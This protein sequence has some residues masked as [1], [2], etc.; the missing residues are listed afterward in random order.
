M[1][2][3]NRKSRNA[4]E[5]ALRGGFIICTALLLGLMP[6][7]SSASPQVAQSLATEQDWSVFRVEDGDEQVCW[8]ASRPTKSVAYRDDRQV[9]VKRGDIFLTVSVRPQDD[10]DGEVS[11]ISGYPIRKG[12]SVSVSVGSREFDLFPEGEQAWPPSRAQDDDLVRAF[13]A[14]ID[15]EIE[16]VSHRGTRTVDTFSL[17]G[18]TAA[19]GKARESCP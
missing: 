2:D 6:V 7:T 3:T 13:K 9:D 18:F 4:A 15:A 11:F 12:S 14:G 19:L 17:L 5:D 16:A 10:V 8:I 1:T